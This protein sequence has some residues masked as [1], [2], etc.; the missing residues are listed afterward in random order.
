MVQDQSHLH[1][2]SDGYCVCSPLTTKYATCH[3][4]KYSRCPFSANKDTRYRG[5]VNDEQYVHTITLQAVPAALRIE[6]IETA[7]FQEEELKVVH[8]CLHS[9]DWEK[10][11][12]AFVI[13]RNELTNIGQIVLRGPKRATEESN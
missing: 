3:P 9:G 2:L 11:P 10:A 1:A 13:V 5:Y 8:E 7:S 4:G 6:E 12:K